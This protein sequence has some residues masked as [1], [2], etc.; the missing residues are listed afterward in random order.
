M[1]IINFRANNIK[2][3]SAVDITPD[4]NIVKIT[5][6]NGAGKTSVLDAIWWALDRGTA[7]QAQP[8]RSGEKSG[9]IRLDLG[10][11]IVTRRFTEKTSTLTVED[12]DGT[13]RKSPQA[14]LEA[15][16]GR[17]SFDPLAFTRMRP[18]DQ[19]TT[20]RGIVD[21]GVDIDDLDRRRQAAYDERTAVNRE[22]KAKLARLE[23]MAVPAGAPRRQQSAAELLAEI[24]AASKT[25][26]ANQE[27][28]RLLNELRREA[29]ETYDEIES[30]EALLAAA[31]EK[32]EGDDGILA[33][34][35]KAAAACEELQ[36]VDT[37]ELE[38]RLT[39]LEDHNRQARAAQEHDDL[40]AAQK[41]DQKEAD[42]LTAEIAAIDDEKRAALEAA[43]FPMP[44]LG[45]ADGGVTLDDVPLEQASAAQ[46]LRAS[47]AI[48]MAANPEIRVIRITDGSLL[49]SDSMAVIEQAAAEQ[50]FQV[51]VEMVD[52]TGAVG[53]VIEDGMVKAVNP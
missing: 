22:A 10:D 12:A 15:L 11:L 5:G 13:R 4:G 3:L 43:E 26:Q 48:A 33:R 46:Q 9:D 53:I 27:Q 17:L 16:V 37:A 28:R 35:K 14:V 50:D 44:G 38:D 51:W 39:T 18:A 31:R 25:N 6:K 52:E 49:D 23:S 29:R 30:L 47:L 40:M 36:D 8:I 21:I 1:R 45:F 42:G 24:A 20:L 34:G 32:L 7:V 2:R 19:V 41:A